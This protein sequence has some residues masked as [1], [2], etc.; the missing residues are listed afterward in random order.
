VQDCVD[1]ADPGA[2]EG[3]AGLWGVGAG[4]EQAGEC[5]G[6]SLL[7]DAADLAHGGV[8]VFDVVLAQFVGA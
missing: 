8:E 1:A 7:V 6:G 3:A 5:A 4:G 2:A